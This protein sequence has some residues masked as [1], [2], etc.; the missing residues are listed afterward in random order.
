MTSL[1]MLTLVV[2]SFLASRLT[3]GE[4]VQ[5]FPAN[6]PASAM[7]TQWRIVWGVESHGG[8]SEVLYIRQAF[9]KRSRSS[10]EIRVLDDCRLAEI[11]VPYNGGGR[12][13]DISGYSFSLVQLDKSFLGPACVGPGII[14]NSEGVPSETGPVASEVH[15]GQLRWINANDDSRRGQSIAIWSVLDAAN[16]RYIMLYQFRDDGQIGFRLG[17]T[18]HNL[19]NDDADWTTHLPHGVVASQSGPW[20]CV[21]NCGESC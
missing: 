2:A 5:H 7:D 18:A 16:Y 21:S 20:R 1:R 4:I 15:D 12:I 13:Y 10:P 9:F 8:Q 11:F 17:A 14:Y 3:A 19:N 6:G